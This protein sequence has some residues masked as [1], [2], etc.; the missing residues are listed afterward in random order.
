MRLNTQCVTNI[1]LMLQNFCTKAKQKNSKFCLLITKKLSRI[2]AALCRLCGFKMTE[3]ESEKRKEE[4]DLQKVGGL[5]S[6]EEQPLENN[7][8]EEQ[9]VDLKGKQEKSNEIQKNE[10]SNDNDNN[11]E[12]I[13]DRKDKDNDNNNDNENEN[14]NENDNIQ[15]NMQNA[16]KLQTMRDIS[17]MNQR[18]LRK[19]L[20]F[21]IYANKHKQEIEENNNEDLE[22]KRLGHFQM[23]KRQ[24]IIVVFLFVTYLTVLPARSFLA[25]IIGDMEPDLNFDSN[26]SAQLL[27]VAC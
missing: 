8:T 16:M 19:Q 13:D 9:T 15:Q 2:F 7:E 24:K 6:N 27:L 5:S 25:A 22:I 11:N 10:N 21:I 1:C 12:Q 3:S 14:E 17:A 20:T 18:T 26:D 4:I 23:T